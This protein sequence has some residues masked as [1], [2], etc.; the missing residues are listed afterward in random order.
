[1]QPIHFALGVVFFG[2]LPILGSTHFILQWCSHDLPSARSAWRNTLLGAAIP[3]SFSGWWIF[4]KV[5]FFDSIDGLLQFHPLASSL[6]Y[7]SFLVLICTLHY[8]A[9]NPFRQGIPTRCPACNNRRH[10]DTPLCIRCGIFLL[11][12]SPKP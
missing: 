8:A 1:M 3:F 10:L 6:L 4:Q 9:R 11:P 5:P 7:I 12:K 2:S